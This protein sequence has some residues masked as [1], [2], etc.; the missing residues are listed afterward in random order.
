MRFRMP[1]ALVAIV[2]GA[3]ETAG[4]AQELIFQGILRSLTYPLIAGTIGIV[5]GGLLLASGI[6][7]LVGAH[8]T[9]MLVKAT[10]FVSVPTFIVIGIATHVAGWPATAI[11]ILFPLLLFHYS[12]TSQA[13]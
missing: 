9:S 2:L 4:G 10:M 7:L 13:A 8:V 11:G 6:A 3:L 5:A 12:R 1:I